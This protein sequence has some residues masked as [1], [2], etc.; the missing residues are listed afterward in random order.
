MNRL[1]VIKHTIMSINIKRY[2][3]PYLKYITVG[4][5]ALVFA[6]EHKHIKKNEFEIIR[7]YIFLI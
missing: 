3:P 6:N 4:M 1:S 7:K 5:R 2:P